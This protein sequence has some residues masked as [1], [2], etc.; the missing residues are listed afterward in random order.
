VISR[1]LAEA[2]AEKIVATKQSESQ[3]V[4][5]SVLVRLLATINEQRA[6]IRRLRKEK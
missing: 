6:L 5:V 3:W 4:A 1:K 2:V